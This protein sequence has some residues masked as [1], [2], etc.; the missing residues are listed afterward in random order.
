MACTP[1]SEQRVETEQHP[2]RGNP[3]APCLGGEDV[4]VGKT[5]ERKGYL[6][7][8]SPRHT[9]SVR[10][11]KATHYMLWSR[12]PSSGAVS[13]LSLLETHRLTST[14]AAH[15]SCSDRRSPLHV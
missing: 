15:P 9:L 8:P 1:R 13:L 6:P 11:S 5:S 12:S 3:P 2:R 14:N 4:K 7:P 10:I